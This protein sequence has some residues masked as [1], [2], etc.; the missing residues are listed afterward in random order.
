VRGRG[1]RAADGVEFAVERV[2]QVTVGP[3]ARSNGVLPGQRIGYAS[4]SVA[5]SSRGADRVRHGPV[6]VVL[7]V[8]SADE[9]PSTFRY[10]HARDRPAVMIS[11]VRRTRTREK[12][13][14][15]AIWMPRQGSVF[16]SSSSS[17]LALFVWGR[18][19]R[20]GRA[21]GGRPRRGRTRRSGAA[22]KRLLAPLTMQDADTM[23]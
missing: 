19:E 6:L 15:Y 22:W 8:E 16:L 9:L 21:V 3:Q 10:S 13:S 14:K 18:S 20:G 1:R 11:P 23:A 17:S 7:V 12:H 5:I 2:R 4:T